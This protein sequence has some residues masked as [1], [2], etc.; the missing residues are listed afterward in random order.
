MTAVQAL[1]SL[2][3]R[4]RGVVGAI[5]IRMPFHNASKSIVGGYVT[6][7]GQ[8]GK[9]P[10][11]YRK[12]FAEAERKPDTY[13]VWSQ[14]TPIAW[15]TIDDADGHHSWHIVRAIN[16]SP[17]TPKHVVLVLRAAKA[18]NEVASQYGFTEGEIELW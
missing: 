17:R 14:G 15:H 9:L 8:Y 2:E 12:W 6:E 7:R 1:P 10:H 16:Y 13:V 3:V 4:M 18:E 5:N 11:P